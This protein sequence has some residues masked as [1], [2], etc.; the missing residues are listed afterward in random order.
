MRRLTSKMTYF[1]KRIFA[2]FFFGFLVFVGMS[3]AISFF[4]EA[5]QRDAGAAMMF[6]I[7]PAFMAFMGY[8]LSKMLIF[9]LVDDVQ[10]GGNHLVVTNNKVTHS[11]KLSDVLNVSVSLMSAPP[12]HYVIGAS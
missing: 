4:S 7:A 9:D 1:H 12:T 2:R 8:R 11:I 5:D 10:D 6:I 3:G